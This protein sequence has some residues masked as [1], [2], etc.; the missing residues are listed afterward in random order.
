[1]SDH[2][3]KLIEVT[4]SS[5]ISSDDAIQN[6]IAKTSESVSNLNW[7]EVTETRG[8]IVKGKVAHWQVSMKI[9]FRIAD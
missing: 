8:H 7:F 6:A 5:K 9:G 1:M 4:G 2:V 3:Y